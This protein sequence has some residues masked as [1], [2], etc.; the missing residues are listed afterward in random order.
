VSLG[1]IAEEPA[2]SVPPSANAQRP[3]RLRVRMRRRSL[4]RQIAAGLRPDSDAE[5]A[6]RSLQLTSTHER[7]CIAT[8]LMNILEA[9]DERHA[10]PASRLR[11][12]HAEVLVARHEI[13]ALISALRSEQELAA[14]G[15]A[16]AR[17]LTEA[18]DSPML[19]AEPGRTV[20]QATSEAISAL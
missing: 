17:L 1:L 10:D 11:L 4:D 5:L 9:A 12:N 19:H 6:L 18:G 14:R 13:I 15:I 8:A 20:R 16:R 2:A 3:L 7:R